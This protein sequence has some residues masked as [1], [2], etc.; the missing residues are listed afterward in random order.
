MVVQNQ[1]PM[2][3]L[4]ADFSDWKLPRMVIMK[5]DL[6]EFFVWIEE[7]AEGETP[8]QASRH[9]CLI[10]SVL[11]TQ[12]VDFCS[13]KGE[14]GKKWMS[15]SMRGFEEFWSRPEDFLRHILPGWTITIMTPVQEQQ[16]TAA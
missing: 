3:T 16:R 1:E 14:S 9:M 13:I 15:I 11:T 4:T 12:R 10:R 6:E 8:Q 2:Y 5:M 7:Q